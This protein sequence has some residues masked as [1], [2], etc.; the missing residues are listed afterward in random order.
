VARGAGQGG[1]PDVTAI[2]A[3]LRDPLYRFGRV[4]QALD[5]R[6][7]TVEAGDGWLDLGCHNGTFLGMV[8]GRYAVRAMGVDVFDPALKDDSSWEYRQR[9]LDGGFDLGRRF[10]F[11]SALEILEHMV[12][13]D[14]FLEQCRRHNED[15]G[16][17]ILTTP[18]IN[19]LRNRL[20][21][22]LGTYP[23]GLEYRNVVHHVRL[24]NV[25]VLKAHLGAHGYRVEHVSGVSFLPVR[26]NHLRPCRRLSEALAERWPQLC[27]S[28]IVIAR[29]VD[30]CQ[31]AEPETPA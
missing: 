26:I 25:P 3:E 7:V 20:A 15:G 24:Y 12:D 31:A 6:R 29:K 16:H 8:T 23:A 4:L 9:D 14:L 13:T 30:R 22:P 11:I 10:R 2:P 17:L 18:N 1:E 28:L 5:R 21:V 19:S 27:G